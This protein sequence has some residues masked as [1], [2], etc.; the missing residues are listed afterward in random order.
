MSLILGCIFTLI[1]TIP[2]FLRLIYI[3]LGHSMIIIDYKDT[4]SFNE[5]MCLFRVVVSDG[6]LH[7]ELQGY[8][9]FSWTDYISHMF[10]YISFLY[11][12]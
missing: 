11:T 2:D 8:L 6:S 1:T 12:L 9:T 7:Y 3:V 4:L 5:R 10:L